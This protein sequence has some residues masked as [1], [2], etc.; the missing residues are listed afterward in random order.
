DDDGWEA[1][2]RGLVARGVLREDRSPAEDRTLD[3]VLG[4]VLGAGSSLRM[5]FVYARGAGDSRHE[6]LWM[7]G[8]AVVRQTT[9]PDGVHR[10]MTGQRETVDELLALL[11]DVPTGGDSRPGEPLTLSGRAYAEAVS[12]TRSEGAA[13]AA[14]RHPAAA[15][16]VAALA[17]AGRL[18]DV[19]SRRRVGEDRYEGDALTLV[20]SPGAGLWLVRHEA[21]SEGDPDGAVQ[22]RRIAPGT[23][24]EL[25]AALVAEA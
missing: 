2:A 1:V 4:L 19:E 5:T 20:Q 7:E 10:F 3:A 8:D 12:V 21:P 11:I 15:E 16:F 9:T 13:V 22:L 6:V 23:A 14:Q 25:V 17:D 18:T 24:R